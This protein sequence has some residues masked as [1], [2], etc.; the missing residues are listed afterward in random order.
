ME[1]KDLLKKLEKKKVALEEKLDELDCM[2][3]AL[4]EQKILP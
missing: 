3:D 2:I 4:N 1:K